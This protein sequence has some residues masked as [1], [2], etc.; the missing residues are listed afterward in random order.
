MSQT[1]QPPTDPYELQTYQVLMR[2]GVSHAEAIMK[3]QF[4][5]A[6]KRTDPTGNTVV[7]PADSPVAQLDA[8]HNDN[9][10]IETDPT[11]GRKEFRG[12]FQP[13][14]GDL[15]APS[16]PPVALS[17]SSLGT[18]PTILEYT[19]NSWLCMR[20]PVDRFS[21]NPGQD[22]YIEIPGSAPSMFAGGRDL[23]VITGSG[24]D[25]AVLRWVA[26]PIRHTAAFTESRG[27]VA[28]LIEISLEGDP[29]EYWGLSTP[30]GRQQLENYW[31]RI[32][33]WVSTPTDNQEPLTE[34]HYRQFYTDGDNAT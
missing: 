11:T 25:P 5:G 14:I 21:L 15:T 31:G 26:W 6:L 30:E 19:R 32:G 4:W 8:K 10:R 1:F 17:S 33:M 16:M 18:P 2:R 9:P 3:A 20:T 27:V 23:P 13:R 24:V 22:Y 12:S 29:E 7:G 34:E 28:Q